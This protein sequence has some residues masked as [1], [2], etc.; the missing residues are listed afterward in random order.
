MRDPKVFLHE[1]EILINQQ[2]RYV[3]GMAARCPAEGD[4]AWDRLRQRYGVEKASARPRRDRHRGAPPEEV[5][6]I[7]ES[8]RDMARPAL[9][10]FEGQYADRIQHDPAL[11]GWVR[12]LHGRL[13]AL[14]E[15]AT[16]PRAEQTA[17]SPVQSWTQIAV[18]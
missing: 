18:S 2:V 3:V 13:A 14:H 7:L 12:R 11:S 15:L 5:R 1:L 8:I 16:D 9:R 10:H 17:R 4:E 6:A